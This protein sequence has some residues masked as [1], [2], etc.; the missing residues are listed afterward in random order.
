MGQVIFASLSV[1]GR[2]QPLLLE[3]TITSLAAFAD[4]QDTSFDS[5]F[6]GE[7]TGWTAGAGVTVSGTG[8]IVSTDA[9]WDDGVTK[10]DRGFLYG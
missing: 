4:L 3:E 7:G 10:Y 1:I 5:L 2:N 9:Y 8:G 6:D